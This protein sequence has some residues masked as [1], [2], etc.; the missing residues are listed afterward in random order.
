[1]FLLKVEKYTKLD[2][3][4]TISLRQPE[5]QIRLDISQN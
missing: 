1:M 2:A 4:L 5:N 3:T